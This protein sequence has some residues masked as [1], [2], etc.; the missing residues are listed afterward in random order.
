MRIIIA[1]AAE[2]QRTTIS[3]PALPP[4]IGYPVINLQ[5]EPSLGLHQDPVDAAA[6]IKLAVNRIF[7][8]STGQDVTN[9]LESFHAQLT[10]DGSCV[11][12]LEIRPLEFAPDTV[13][14]DNALGI[15]TFNGVASPPAAVPSNLNHASIRLQGDNQTACL[16]TMELNPLIDA[17]G[18][19]I[20][21]PT[22]SV[23]GLL[24]GDA[25]VG[26][27]IDIYDALYIAEYLAGLRNECTDAV[28]DTCLHTT[29]A[30]SVRQDGAIDQITI[31]DALLITQHLVGLR[32]NSYEIV[33]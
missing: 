13:N 5:A 4:I 33:P 1:A 20:V 16:I 21:V 31:A 18:N 32:G 8:A 28:D 23:G 9:S 26:G 29:N 3:T 14:I 7:D 2:L 17:S 19:S 25:R 22:A 11:N 10:Y 24:R 27:I 6:G 15:T 12:I 30:A